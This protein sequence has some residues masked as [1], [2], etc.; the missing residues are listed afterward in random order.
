MPVN[1]IQLD[2]STAATTNKR[3]ALSL[4]YHAVVV[5]EVSN[6]YEV[7]R[8][9]FRA[10][11]EAAA[12]GSYASRFTFDDGHISHF[13]QAR[14]LLNEAG[15]HG[16]FFIVPT[17]LGKPG[18]MEAAHV[19]QLAAEGHE[20]GSHSLTHPM[21]PSC[22][23]EQLHQELE[24]S[25]KHLEDATGS[26]VGSLSFPGGR[27]NRR[28]LEA[29]T[30]AGY[31]RVFT[32]EPTVGITRVGEMEMVGRINIGRSVTP[33]R[34]LQLLDPQS[35][36]LRAQH[37]RY[38]IKRGAQALMGDRLYHALWRAITGYESET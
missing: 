1:E 18:Y 4:I 23:P 10:H 25:R 2:A 26:P 7:T 29:C 14:P 9:Q 28:V 34:L 20:I 6:S 32:S 22:S 27:Y 24:G 3:N 13:E 33:E 8:E 38:R 21:L 35:G 37:T 19:R 17:W 16:V 11:V 31:S 15:V 12:S 5:G 36:T 30:A